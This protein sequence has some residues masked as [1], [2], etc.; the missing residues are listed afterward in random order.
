MVLVDS[1]VWIDFFR[2]TGTVQTLKL[3]ELLASGEAIVGDLM[4]VEVLQGTETDAAFTEMLGLLNLIE[5]IE[6]CSIGGAVKAAGY[7]R[8][9][10]AKGITVRKTIDILIATRAIR[11]NLPL[12]FSDRDFDPFVAHLGLKDA[13]ALA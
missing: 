5:Q 1:S 9:L 13:M 7:Y 11:D 4:I 12:L 8:F 10:C 2:G 3:R 6:I